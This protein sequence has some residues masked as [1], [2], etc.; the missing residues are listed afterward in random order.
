[1]TEIVGKRGRRLFLNSEGPRPSETQEFWR[2]YE[3]HQLN[4]TRW[5]F[6]STTM[7][8]LRTVPSSVK[9]TNELEGIRKRKDATPTLATTHWVRS[10]LELGM[11]R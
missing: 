4:I 8:A 6:L 10:S 7:I 3:H 5:L 1:M 9:H 2:G 11:P